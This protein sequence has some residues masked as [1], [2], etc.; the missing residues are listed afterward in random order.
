MEIATLDIK[1]QN[2]G[3][4]TFDSIK[5]SILIIKRGKYIDKNNNIS[6]PLF[7]EQNKYYKRIYALEY[8]DKKIYYFNSYG[9]IDTNHGFHVGFNFIEHQKF[10][11]IQGGHW[12]QQ[13]ENLRYCVNIIFLIIGLFL[14]ILKSTK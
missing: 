11:W 4:L 1:E 10:L 6:H 9:K 8:M 13:E 5:S 12:L 2:S 3:L 7:D 14:G